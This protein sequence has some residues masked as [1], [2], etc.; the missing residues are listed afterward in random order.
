MSPVFQTRNVPWGSR[1]DRSG[2]GKWL[3]IGTPGMIG[4]RRP[5]LGWQGKVELFGRDNLRLFGLLFV[6]RIRQ[7]FG[8]IQDQNVFLSIQTTCDLSIAQSIGGA[9]G[10]DLVNDLLKL[11]GKIFGQAAGLLPGENVGEIVLGGEG[12]MGIDRA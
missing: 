8:I 3:A 12:T 11:E 9:I 7:R 4:C 2:F 1:R 6:N 5:A 10:L